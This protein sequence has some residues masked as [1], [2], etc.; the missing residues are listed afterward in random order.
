MS[1]CPD[2]TTLAE[3]AYVRGFFPANLRYRPNVVLMLATVRD[4]G[5][6]QISVASALRA[7]QT[8]AMSSSPKPWIDESDPGPKILKISITF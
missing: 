8:I 2:M 4:V 5:Q 1:T 6:H 3:C 7:R